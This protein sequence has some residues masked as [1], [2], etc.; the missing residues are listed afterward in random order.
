MLSAMRRRYRRELYADRVSRIRET[1]PHACIG[2][3]VIVGFPGETDAEF[4]TTFRFLHALDIAYLHV[5][6]YSERTGTP[7]ADM[8]NAVPVS[9]RRERNARLRALSE[10]KMNAFT[11][12]HRGQVRPVLFEQ[13]ERDGFLE[14][15]SDNYLKI[16]APFRADWVNRVIPVEIP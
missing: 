3:D 2:A 10:L 6:T 14:G 7:A 15:Y 4:E 11:E 13:S 5:F 1:M 12:Q 8:R 9:V 16:T